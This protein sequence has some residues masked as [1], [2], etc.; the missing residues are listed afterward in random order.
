MKLL[1]KWLTEQLQQF[2]LL[3]SARFC[4]Q[5]QL[6]VKALLSPWKRTV[7]AALRVLGLADKSGFGM[8]RL[9]SRARWSSLQANRVLLGLLL[10]TCIPSGPLVLGLDDSAETEALLR[11]ADSAM[12]RVKRGSIKQ[13]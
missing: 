11:H 2:A 4:P 9:L 5:V 12:Y 3:F 13:T 8:F 10:A 1:P 7:T 6:V